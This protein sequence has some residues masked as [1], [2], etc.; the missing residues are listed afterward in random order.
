MRSTL[1]TNALS[2]GP[3]YDA[4]SAISGPNLYLY[5]IKYLLTPYNSM[6]QKLSLLI[7]NYIRTNMFVLQ[8]VMAAQFDANLPLQ[9]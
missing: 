5:R 8:I 3:C 2:I 6:Q 7:V 4:N 1:A 9:A